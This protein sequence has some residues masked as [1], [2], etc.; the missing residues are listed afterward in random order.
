MKIPKVLTIAGIDIEIRT[1]G[2]KDKI[3]LEEAARS[4]YLSQKVFLQDFEGGDV[5]NQAL[6]HEITHWILYIMNR[7]DLCN[8]E[9]FVDHFAHLMYQ[10][11][12]QIK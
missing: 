2:K 9:D 11:H 5:K 12:K 4:E 3:K 1:V 10:V 8:D 6:M 7:F